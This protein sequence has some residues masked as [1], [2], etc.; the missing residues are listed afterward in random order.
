METVGMAQ[1]SLFWTNTHNEQPARPGNHHISAGGRARGSVK[2]AE[3][4]IH[5]PLQ[6]YCK[7]TTVRLLYIYTHKSHNFKSQLCEVFLRVLELDC[8]PHQNT[9]GWTPAKRKSNKLTQFKQTSRCRWALLTRA[10]LCCCVWYRQATVHV[11]DDVVILAAVSSGSS[12]TRLTVPTTIDRQ[13]A[14]ASRLTVSS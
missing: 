13:L 6:L 2:D 5:F 3:G 7:V 14:A 1:I 10:R 8:S 4:C 9:A 12:R 11:S